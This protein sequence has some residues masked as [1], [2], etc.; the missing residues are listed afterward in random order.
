MGLCDDVDHVLLVH[1]EDTIHRNHQNVDRPD[2]GEIIFGQRVMEVVEIG[3]AQPARLGMKIELPQSASWLVVELRMEVGMLRTIMSRTVS[4]MRAG[5]PSSV[6]PR[7]TWAMRRSGGS[8][9]CVA[10]A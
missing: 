10:W 6:Q 1:R 3:D 9:S 7:S 4:M 5:P 2:R 8:V